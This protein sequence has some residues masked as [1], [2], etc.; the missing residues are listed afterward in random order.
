[1]MSINVLCRLSEAQVNS[2]SSLQNL[3]PKA[4]C[5]G[6]CYRTLSPTQPAPK[7][8]CKAS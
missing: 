4:V 2:A 7:L 1:M 3:S 8:T 5:G 6:A